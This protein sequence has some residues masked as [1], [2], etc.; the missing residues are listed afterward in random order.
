MAT[1]D[2][3]TLTSSDQIFSTNH[4]LPQIRGIHKALHVQIDDKAARLRT[5]VGGSYRELLGTA[6]AIVTM[7]GDMETVQGTLGRM[8]GRCGGAV[9]TGKIGGLARFIED[10]GEREESA[11]D[12]MGLVARARLLDACTLAVGRLLSGNSDIGDRGDRLV[13]AAKVLVLSRLLMKSF[14]GGIADPSIAAAV[15]AAEKSSRKLKQKLLRSIDKVLANVG[16]KVK[17]GDVLK[18]LSAYSLAVSAGARDVMRHFLHVRSQAMAFVFEVEDHQQQHERA[19]NPKDVLKCLRLYTKTLIDVQALVPYK[20][21]EVL[22][23]LRKVGLLADES[24]RK[25]EGLR[26]DVY[27]RWCGDEI[28]FFTPFIRHDDLD[29]T[30]ARDMLGM[31]AKKGGDMLMQVLGKTLEGIV[32]FKTIVDLRTEVLKMWIAEGSKAKGF[33]PTVLLNQ[34]KT[35]IGKH[36][37]NVMD[38]KVA[39]LR[40]VGSEV[41]ATL[42][43]WQSGITDNRLSLWGGDL[44]DLDLTQGASQF[45]QNVISRVY[46]RSDAVS[47]AITCYKSWHQIIDDVG[48]VVEQLKK[49]RWDNDV[50]DIED[51]D[52]IEQRQQLLSKEDPQKLS[53]HLDSSLVTAFKGLDTQLTELWGQYSE[54]PENG[55][56]AMYL[57]RILRDIRGKLPT[58]DAVKPFGLA[59]VPLLHVA[60]SRQ[61]L[62]S[63]LDQFTS[64][65]LARKTVVGRSLWEGQPNLPTSPSPGIFKFLRNLSTSMDDAGSD[66]WSPAAVSVLKGNLAAQL[67]KQWLLVLAAHVKEAE[68]K[69]ETETSRQGPE[70]GS[71]E[72]LAEKKDAKSGSVKSPKSGEGKDE[73]TGVSGEG[74]GEDTEKADETPETEPEND[75]DMDKKKEEEE[76]RRKDKEMEKQRQRDLSIQWL[77]DIAYLRCCL[78][79]ATSPRKELTMLE[80]EVFGSTG[81][82]GTEAR[83]RMGKAALEY[84]KKTSLIFGLLM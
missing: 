11:Q 57:A 62:V 37:L 46:G 54:R 32:E 19:R 59:V 13:L 27:E 42:E 64:V 76:T 84:W 28:R 44:G 43:A 25:I 68:D 34:F 83:L 6:E 77:F 1:P 3:S 2:L 51:E 18:T 20:L 31:W 65:F 35:V 61:V 58:L 26:L 45:T 50:D 36:M 14:E 63:P 7:H 12:G 15:E 74:E 41:S 71:E 24:L 55:A 73:S 40:L 70:D 48:Q 80:D 22:A 75:G 72:K 30:Q 38:K 17:L 67:Q 47:K 29:G 56:M 33:D 23:G 53:D 79:G 52:T 16:D 81:L 39:K 60:I 9:V 10:R 78:D 66:L 69:E 4:T 5:R 8:G 49:Q 82:E 21:T